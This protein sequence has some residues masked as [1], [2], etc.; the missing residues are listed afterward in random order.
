MR[1]SVTLRE[2]GALR[3]VA[4]TV[5]QIM[6]SPRPE[7]MT[8][9]SLLRG[10]PE[11]SE[12]RKVLLVVLDG[13]GLG[14]EDETNPIFL[15]DTPVWDRLSCQCPFAT[16]KASGKAVG[17]L[18]GM[19]GNS[20]AGHMNIGAGRVVIQDDARIDLAIANGSVY[21]NPVFLETIEAARRNGALHL[22]A[23]LSER[24]SH[25]SVAYPLALLQLAR[26]KGLK[27]VYVHVIFDGRSTEPGGAPLL[28]EGLAR[29]METT[30]IGQ[31]V[32]GVGRGLA[33][34]R[35]GNYE[36]TRRAYDALVFGIGRAAGK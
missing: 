16:L 27:Q 10:Y 7:L 19:A 35:D 13:W 21:E 28:L 5:L 8:G 36:K 32:S 25:G 26:E 4:P 33:L 15:A 34:D 12:G 9:Q 24:S 11:V 31:I 3:D 6:G 20:E 17:L 14:R 30:G 29:E 1:I 2:G 22:I 23:L 18:E